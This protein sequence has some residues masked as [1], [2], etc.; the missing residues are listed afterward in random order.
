MIRNKKLWIYILLVVL[1]GA[2]FFWFLLIRPRGR[3]VEQVAQP[4]DQ[5]QPEMAKALP[6]PSYMPVGESVTETGTGYEVSGMITSELDEALPEATVSLYRSAPRWAPPDF[7]QP[8]P[9]D[10]KTSD[11]E[12]R[13]QFRMN[14]PAN[15]WIG[16]RKEGY[17]AIYAFLP[18]RNTRATVRDFQLRPATATLVGFVFDKQDTPIPGALVLVNVPPFT[19]VAD[20]AF[21]APTGRLTD[22]G[23]KYTMDGLPDGDVSIVASARAHLMQEELNSLKAGQSLQVD[24]HLPPATPISFVVNNSRGELLPYAT[25]TAPGQIKISG[26]DKRGMIEIS[27]PLELSPFDCTVAAEGYVGKTVLFD[28]KA[29]PG[30]VTLQEQPVLRGRV[31]AETGRPVAE[32]LVSVWGTGGVQGKFDGAVPTDKAGRF[33][34]PLSYPPVRE[35]KVARL[36]YFDQRVTFDSAKPAPAEVSI[37]L[38]RVEAGIFGRVIDYRGLPVKRFVAHLRNPEARPPIQDYQRSFSDDRGAFT[39]TDVAPGN[40]ALI[41][42]SV[43]GTTADDVQIVTRKDVDI[44]KGFLLGEILVQFPPPQFKK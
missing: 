6:E 18:V 41:I 17:A 30:A 22:A 4:A 13:Y 7:G 43:Q 31:T 37:R 9:L 35:I 1:A 2:Y 44:R 14:A 29:P 24:F 12:G 26:G 21:L 16:I 36:G 32:A 25:A 8:A 11:L 19:P 10:T 15:V 40:Y 27:V 33:T 38:K 23:G 3:T 34:L 39:I 20:N 5:A 42:Q 28:P